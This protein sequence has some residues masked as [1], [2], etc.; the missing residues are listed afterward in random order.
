MF[1]KTVLRICTSFVGC[2]FVLS[3]FAKAMDTGAFASLIGSYG[4]PFM[5]FAAPFMV[6]AEIALGIALVLELNPRRDSLIA[7]LFLISFTGAFAFAHF[8]NGVNDCGCFGKLRPSS[9][10]PLESFIQNA[11]LMTLCL[12]IRLKYP[13]GEKGSPFTFWKKGLTLSLIILGVFIS[14]LTF[15]TPAV[16]HFS[17]LKNKYA[18]QNINN[19]ELAKY[20]KASPGKTY[21]VFCFSYTCTHCWNSVENVQGFKKSGTVDSVI[22]LAVGD[23]S[24]KIYFNKM[25]TPDFNIQTLPEEAF[26]KISTTYPVGF[27]VKNDTIKYVIDGEIPSS[28]TF[29]KTNNIAYNPPKSTTVETSCTPTSCG[30]P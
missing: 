13:K 18:N 9:W 24:S 6:V 7:L 2:F 26:D 15:S 28:I 5:S 4:F 22:A 16:F 19:T 11:I 20:V 12:I 21:M 30:H 14:G 27:Y 23:D 29:R 10:G 1:N 25:F 3:G 8:H 17:K